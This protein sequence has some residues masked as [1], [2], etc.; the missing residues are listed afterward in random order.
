[1]FNEGAND[2][3]PI[4]ELLDSS[5]SAS[6]I[7]T[8][9]SSAF[10]APYA[11]DQ[12]ALNDQEAK[13]MEAKERIITLDE[14]VNLLNELVFTLR[15][16]NLMK[17]SEPYAI[18]GSQLQLRQS[19]SA[20]N[21]AANN[22][23]PAKSLEFAQV[24]R[25]TSQDSGLEDATTSNHLYLSQQ[26]NGT[27]R[28]RAQTNTFLSVNW[29]QHYEIGITIA[30]ICATL[31]L[32]VL[33]LTLIFVLLRSRNQPAQMDEKPVA[34]ELR[35][36]KA[37]EPQRIKF[38]YK[39]QEDGDQDQTDT[40]IE[41]H[42]ELELAN[43]ALWRAP[44]EEV[45]S[46][47]SFLAPI[48]PRTNMVYATLNQLDQ[49][50]LHSSHLS[51]ASGCKHE[52]QQQQHLSIEQ[53]HQFVEL[54]K[55]TLFVIDGSNAEK[56]TTINCSDFNIEDSLSLRDTCNESHLQTL[57]SRDEQQ[58]ASFCSPSTCNSS[59]HYDD[60]SSLPTFTTSD[61]QPSTSSFSQLQQPALESFTA[62]ER[63]KQQLAS[64]SNVV[65]RSQQ[66][67]DLP[68]TT[69]QSSGEGGQEESVAVCSN[70]NLYLFS[71]L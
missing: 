46:R 54:G 20:A 68:N 30:G 51:L 29:A 7:N 26:P 25:S 32:S 9:S 5:S 50:T 18:Y 47:V 38:L 41:P 31:L 16:S 56:L 42:E 62:I 43:G 63:K 33:T 39:S 10:D 24:L 65:L 70:S 12:E 69:N 44:V 8:D 4:S 36:S 40:V 61:L 52:Q 58:V 71:F 15:A 28:M 67:R 37:S 60:Q 3:I 27:R 2:R 1:M 55:E 35:S 13:S 57:G 48:C 34:L 19:Q 6:Q 22:Q 64:N 11:P 49:Q 17:T 59:L 14:Q 66:L 53:Q 23:A 21:R 45:V